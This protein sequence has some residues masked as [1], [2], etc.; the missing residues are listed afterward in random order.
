MKQQETVRN[1]GLTPMEQ[2]LPK[3]KDDEG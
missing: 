2:P 1:I 3:R